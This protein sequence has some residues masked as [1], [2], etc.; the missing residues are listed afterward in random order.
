M[1]ALNTDIVFDFLDENRPIFMGGHL[2]G[3]E[4]SFG[5]LSWPQQYSTLMIKTK[6]LENPSGWYVL[7]KSKQNAKLFFRFHKLP[8]K[9]TEISH[10]FEEKVE[11]VGVSLWPQQYVTAYLT[12]DTRGSEREWG[13]KDGKGRRMMEIMDLIN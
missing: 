7:L 9:T 10:F 12:S 5:V 3:L 1:L 13:D 6:I 11:K 4:R 8:L 2:Q